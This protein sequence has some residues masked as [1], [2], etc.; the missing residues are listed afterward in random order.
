[1]EDPHG[2][3]FEHAGNP[4]AIVDAAGLAHG[5][6]AF[7]AA[8]GER[9]VPLARLLGEGG[10]AQYRALVERVR[11]AG[12]AELEAVLRP[13]TGEGVLYQLRV[14]GR[15]PRLFLSA[16]PVPELARAREQS[17]VL[18]R[19]LE[20]TPVVLT[21]TDRTGAI[22]LSDGK[23]LAALGFAP[24]DVLGLDVRELYRDTPLE[25][26]VQRALRGENVYTRCS[27]EGGSTFDHWYTSLVAEDGELEG[28]IGIAV[29][30]TAQTAAEREL[31]ARLEE[32]QRKDATIRALSAP[33]PQAW[34]GILCVPIVGAVDAARGEQVMEALLDGIT[35]RRARF[36]IL[37]LTGA[38]LLDSASAAHVLRLVQAASVLG[39]EGLLCGMRPA[40]ASTLVALGV[41]LGE[42]RATL[43][44]RDALR[45]CLRALD[46]A[47]PR[48]TAGGFK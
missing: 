30:T 24:S 48:R 15:S 19:L 34:E 45:A 12:H 17:R 4:L 43:R 26:A 27:F 37:D 10:E 33:V 44:L 22:T 18:S 39:A 14:T 47:G 11:E 21:A 28:I 38:E 13:R 7:A 41:D 46:G 40:V 9:A 2:D 20:A 31:G 23:G 1:M 8:V 36:V 3:V 35:R 25:D 32:I 29:D 42:V 5:N 16:W 6:A